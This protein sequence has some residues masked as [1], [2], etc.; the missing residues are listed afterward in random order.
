[1]KLEAAKI[2]MLLT[3]QLLQENIATYLLS[4]EYV[5]LSYEGNIK[6][7]VYSRV[8]LMVYNTQ[9]YWV[10]GLSPTQLENNLSDTVSV[11]ILR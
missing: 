10:F 6:Q 11:F 2:Q 7:H 9:N 5:F 8:L 1:L 3:L 4:V